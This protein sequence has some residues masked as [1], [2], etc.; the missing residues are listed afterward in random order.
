MPSGDTSAATGP[1]DER[2]REGPG[3]DD[4]SA[5]GGLIAEHERCVAGLAYRLLGWRADVEDVVQDVFVAALENLPRFRGECRLATWLY[6]ITVNQ[7]RRQRR[8]RL[9]RHKF[10]GT[11]PAL[12]RRA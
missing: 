1:G 12:G 4:V 8:K 6:R 7:C 3:R 10:W 2:L 11:P 9:L 5:F